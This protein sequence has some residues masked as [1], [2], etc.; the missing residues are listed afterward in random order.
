MRNIHINISKHAAQRIAERLTMEP[1][2]VADQLDWDL[3]INIGEEKGTRRIHRLFY[4][5]EDAQC[6][7]AI[8]VQDKDCGHHP[9]R[10]LFRNRCIQ[11]R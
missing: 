11:N 10:R 7:V 9:T 8:Q 5:P 1:G 3:A 4:S 2:E 6:F